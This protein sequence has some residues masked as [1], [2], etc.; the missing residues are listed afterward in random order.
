MRKKTLWIL[1]VCMATL[2]VTSIF[3]WA[4]T[5]PEIPRKYEKN[6][7][8]NID[9]QEEENVLTAAETFNYS[10][11]LS[12]ERFDGSSDPEAYLH[13]GT[14]LAYTGANFIDSE[15]LNYYGTRYE[16]L[17]GKLDPQYPKGIELTYESN[18]TKFST[19]RIYNSPAPEGATWQNITIVM[20][21]PNGS[22]S[23]S[24]PMRFFYKNQ[25]DYQMTGWDYDF[26]FSDCYVVEMKLVYSEYY[27]PVA[28]FWS[29]VHQIVVLDRNFAP[30]LIGLNSGTQVA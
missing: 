28:A 21:A 16:N 4:Q 27:A 25:S 1:V 11:I 22:V 15:V 20:S 18:V 5:H 7:A 2:V 10:K 29:N 13:P 8:R 19:F 6:I 12:L 14:Y 17:Q 24:G 9:S 30:V 26:N 3:V 23:F